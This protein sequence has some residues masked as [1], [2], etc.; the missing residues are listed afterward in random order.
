MLNFPKAMLLWGA[1]ALMTTIPGAASEALVEEVL[2]SWLTGKEG[3]VIEIYKCDGERELCG[4]ITWLKK[5]YTHEGEL[6]RDSRN[7]DAS[8]RDRPRCGIIVVTGLRRIDED[9]WA[10]GRVY[11]PKSGNRYRA[12]LDLNDD[13]TIRIRAYIGIPLVGKSDTWTRPEGIDIGCPSN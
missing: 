3:A 9:T 1:I 5:P 13:G 8:L 2:G 7:P 12:Y 6:K 11:N 10:H 4:R